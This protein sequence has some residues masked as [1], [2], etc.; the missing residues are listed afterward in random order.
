MGRSVIEHGL[1]EDQIN[2]FL[3]AS[4]S[5]AVSEI[6]DDILAFSKVMGDKEAQAEVT[7][8]LTK[9]SDALMV[10]LIRKANGK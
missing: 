1:T 10:D 8:I 6:S 7:K 3:L 5:V 4:E 2:L 9:R